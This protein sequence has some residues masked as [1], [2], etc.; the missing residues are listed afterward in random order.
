MAAS[1]FIR[2]SQPGDR[3]LNSFCLRVKVARIPSAE[4]PPSSRDLEAPQI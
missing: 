2:R 3:L 4:L 1:T